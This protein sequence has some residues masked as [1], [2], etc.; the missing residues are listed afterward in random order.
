MRF[1]RLLGAVVVFYSFSYLYYGSMQF[2]SVLRYASSAVLIK[3]V[4]INLTIGL[5]MFLIGVGVLLAKEW[6]R[7][8]LLVTATVL[9]LVHALF[10]RLFVAYGYDL[11]Q[12]IWNVSLTGFIVLLSWLNLTKP[13]VK[14]YFR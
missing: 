1:I 8:A 11:T 5:V 10:L 7:V 13:S 9:L 2:F 6:A 3:Y 12:Q 14:K 4:A